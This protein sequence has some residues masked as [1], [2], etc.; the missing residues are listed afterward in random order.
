MQLKYRTVAEE[1][2]ELARLFDLSDIVLTVDS[3]P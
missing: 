3:S 2:L 1:L